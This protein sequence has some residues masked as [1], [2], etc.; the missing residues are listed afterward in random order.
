MEKIITPSVATE[1]DANGGI[2]PVYSQQMKGFPGL[3]QGMKIKNYRRGS[4][5][6]TSATSLE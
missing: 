3:L 6:F 5:P 2:S 1:S 4:G